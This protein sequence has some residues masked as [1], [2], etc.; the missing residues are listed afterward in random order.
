[1]N[2]TR[3]YP[4]LGPGTYR[5]VWTGVVPYHLAFQVGIVATGTA[6]VGLSSSALDVGL[7]VGAWG[8][9]ILF[10][11][12][13]GGVAADRYSRRRTMLLSQV[14]LGT[15]ALVI[16]ALELAGALASWHLVMLGLLQGTVYAFFAPART[17]YT[18]RAVVAPLVPNAIAAYSLSEHVAAIAGPAVGGLLL[19]TID[20]ALGWVFVIIAATHAVVWLVF[21]GLPEQATSPAVTGADRVF[22]RI[23][24]GILYARG[25]PSLRVVLTLSAAAM[26]LGM[27]FR[28]LMP[29]FAEQV[30]H[31]GAAGLGTLLAAAGIGA[32]LGSISVSQVRSGG[33]LSRLPGILGV[34][35]GLA[36]LA[37]ALAPSY[38]AAIGLAAVAGGVAA[39]FTTLNSAVVASSPNPAFYGRAASL[40]QL[41]FALG[42]L[43]AIPI[44]A[45]AD[46]IGAPQ[47]V[48]AGGVLLALLSPLIARQLGRDT[49]STNAG[50]RT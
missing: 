5:R 37:F 23:R 35:L 14:V 1:M 2:L 3:Y 4:S 20:V 33:W 39:A 32:I 19:A 17:A 26:L 6:A 11:P 43:G 44:A 8:L 10:L 24:E 40:Y 46:R 49:S 7:V 12:P 29:I 30:H 28:Q 21:E 16:G 41:T 38:L 15:S 42:P 45:L 25:V 48:A 34:L 22:D 13:F 36:A 27:P 18:A 31:A 50:D 47:A 9:P